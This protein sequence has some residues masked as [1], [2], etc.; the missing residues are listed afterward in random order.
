MQGDPEGIEKT[1]ARPGVHGRHPAW[2]SCP[3]TVMTGPPRPMG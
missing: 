1:A 3:K 2:G